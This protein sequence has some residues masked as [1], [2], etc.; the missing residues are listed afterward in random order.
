MH[1]QNDLNL[2]KNLVVYISNL[3]QHR[4]SE[5]KSEINDANESKKNESKSSA[6]D[7]YETSREMIQQTLN[8]LETQLKK[9]ELLLQDCKQIN[10]NKNYSKIENGCLVKT[11]EYVFFI[12]IPLGKIEFENTS[13][14]AISLDSPIGNAL[15]NK[16]AKDSFTF[17]N[18]SIE[19]LMIV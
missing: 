13:Y 17:L 3:I 5:I 8:N 7:K 11:N 14:Y 18:K 12:G 9:Y 19:I 6:G 16:K 15:K 1:L 4:I 2:K 10:S